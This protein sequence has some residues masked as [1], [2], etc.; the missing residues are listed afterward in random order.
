MDEEHTRGTISFFFPG[1][2][3]CLL[4]CS[5]IL[6][7]DD[8]GEYCMEHHVKQIKFYNILCICSIII[9][10]IL[11]YFY[12]CLF[13]FFIYSL[14]TFNCQF[15]YFQYETYDQDY[16]MYRSRNTLT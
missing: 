5:Y 8:V 7:R 1:T 2:P 9:V 4:V 3:I 15:I 11:F 10:T 16:F 12:S 14:C 6:L 13:S